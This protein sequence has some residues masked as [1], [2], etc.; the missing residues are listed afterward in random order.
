MVEPGEETFVAQVAQ[1]V[2]RLVPNGLREG[3]PLRGLV[4]ASWIEVEGL[5]WS[6]L[7]LATGL[8]HCGVR[9]RFS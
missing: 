8:Q 5:M 7:A 2:C 1:E 3:N 4:S 9:L 6:P